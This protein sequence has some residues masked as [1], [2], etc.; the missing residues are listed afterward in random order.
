MTTLEITA[1]SKTFDEVDRK[2]NDYVV[3][4]FCFFSIVI[5]ANSLGITSED[6][7]QKNWNKLIV[8]CD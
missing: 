8:Q 7:W 4:Y 3:F 1:H 5:T 2:Q 6:H